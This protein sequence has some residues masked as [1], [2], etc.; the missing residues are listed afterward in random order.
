MSKMRM[1]DFALKQRSLALEQVRVKEWPVV[2]ELIVYRHECLV[3]YTLLTEQEL[4]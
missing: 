2:A 3:S 1:R 4:M